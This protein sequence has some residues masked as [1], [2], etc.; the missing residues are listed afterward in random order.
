LDADPK[1]HLLARRSISIR[2]GDRFLNLHG[3]LHG[4]DRA[5][6][7]GD[8]TVASRVEDSPR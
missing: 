8:E 2:L 1:P 5:G 7:I 6:E 3:A 4:I